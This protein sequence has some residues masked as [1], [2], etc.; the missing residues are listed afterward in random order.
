MKR[1]LLFLLI[2]IFSF[3]KAEEWIYFNNMTDFEYVQ[4]FGPIMDF[5]VSRIKPDGSEIEIIMEDVQ[6]SDFSEDGK[7]ILY[8][9]QEL[10]NLNIYNKET[11]DTISSIT[12]I[13]PVNTRFTL[14]ENI[15]LYL[16]GSQNSPIQTLYK[17]SFT[18]S[19]TIMLSDSLSTSFN[20]MTISPDGQQIVYFKVT[21]D[22]NTE[23]DIVDVDVVVADIQ[24]GES[25]IL[26]TIPY[27]DISN[28]G[29]FY[30]NPYWGNDG[31]IYLSF[32]AGNCSQ[33]FRIHSSLGYI[34]QLTDN[35]CSGL[36]YYCISS[37]L[38]S[39]ETNLDKFVYMNCGNDYG[40]WIYDIT[41][42]ESSYLGNFNP[43]SG[44]SIPMDQ[45]W[46]P[47]QTKVVFNEWI[48]GGVI[49]IPGY[50]RVYD[51]VSESIDTVGNILNL[52][53]PES[54][55]AAGPIQWIGE[56]YPI[57]NDISDQETNEEIPLIIEVSGFSEL[58]LELSYYAESNTLG[59]PVSMDSTTLTIGLQENWNGIGTV[60]V[61]VF[62]TNGLHDS[63]SFQVTVLPVNDA[64]M[65]FNMIYPMVLDTIPVS[66]DTDETIPFT[67]GRSIDV[68]SEVLYKLT[69]TL[70]YF[71]TSYTN[72]Y[73]NIADTT[74]GVSA[75][76]YAILMTNLNLSRWNIDYTIEG[77]DGEY[78]VN[79]ENGEFVLDNT[80]LSID[81]D[82]MPKEFVLYQNYP[83][84][85]NPITSLRYDL[86]NDG[87]VNI[88]I[89]DMMG[90]IVKTLVNSSQ[91]AGFKYVQWNATNDRD[92]P[93]SAG[94][95]LYTIQAGE[96]RQTRKMVLLK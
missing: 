41:S 8:I 43:E 20:N 81:N 16:E 75:Y 28:A 24:N 13:Y 67:W 87:L 95:Y 89:Y 42:N 45:S 34:T 35:P 31:F 23:D 37:I 25:A 26:A 64:P 77:T 17:Y 92:E 1:I 33:I 53:D 71:G 60:S 68:D 15:V 72:E 21:E 70:N 58:G 5:S 73:E 54:Y 22:E 4:F 55:Y 94:L 78:T 11:M 2:L 29:L 61:F 56:S 39:H 6:Y 88:T 27:F 79:S 48:L 84:P 19:S 57:I 10:L 49:A 74:Y 9:D 47:N 90:R 63:T 93:V 91:T 44:V 18:D 12:D 46:S 86:P 40:Y 36:G 83:N 52:E 3:S 50:M 59:M 80:S 69:I 38:R 65:D 7:K 30:N 66:V 14:D 76:E 82:I 85:F 51:T 62:D 32:L 96:F